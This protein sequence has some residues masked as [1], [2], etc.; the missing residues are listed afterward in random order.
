[1]KFREWVFLVL[2]F[3]VAVS[4]ATL[5]VHIQSPWR[6][7][8]SKD[9]YYL[10]ILGGA[11]GGYTAT[12]G[13]GSP[14]ITVDEGDGW[15]SYTWDKDLSDFQDWMTFTVSIFPNTADQNYNNNNGEQWKEFGEM[16][17]AALFGTDKEIWLYTDVA[18]QTFTKS[19]MAPGSKIMWFKSP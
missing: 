11:G 9:G 15:F 19:F 3:F 13:E 8:A 5:T 1:M 2:C 6:E 7:D 16:K 10:H 17:I 12:Y 14:T 18:S 4:H